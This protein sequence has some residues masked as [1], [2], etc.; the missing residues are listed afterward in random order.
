MLKLR[1]VCLGLAMACVAVTTP[2]SAELRTNLTYTP[3]EWPQALAGDLFT[4]EECNACPVVMLIHG[5]SWR[6]GKRQDMKAFAEALNARGY[7]AFTISYRLVPDYRFPAQLEDVQQALR[8]LHQH[9]S[10]L[11]VDGERI[12]VWGYSAGAHLASLAGLVTETP[13]V[14][15]VVAG[16]LPADLIYSADS[17]LVKALLDGEITDKPEQFRAASPLHQVTPAAP[18]TFLYHARWDWIVAPEHARRMKAAL[19]DAGVPA[20]LVWL[21]GR[22]HV[23]GFFWFG[24]ARDPAIDF[25]DRHL[26]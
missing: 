25:L 8:W 21:N 16:G 22:G 20:E 5:G 12:G 6:S 2:V 11:G 1:S 23:A 14:R 15:A 17:P 3:P 19:D 18:P 9:A 4:P 13:R 26:R 10:S 24:A 7:A